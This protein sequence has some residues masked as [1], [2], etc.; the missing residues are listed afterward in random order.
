MAIGMS[1]PETASTV[2]TVLHGHHDLAIGNIASMNILSLLIA[3]PLP[4]LLA[5]WLID[6]VILSQEYVAMLLMNLPLFVIFFWT[7]KSGKKIG[8]S[9]GTC[10]LL[11]D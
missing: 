9:F 1:L 10:F 3:L 6:P 7:M 8:H 11:V 4:G 5:A 2:A